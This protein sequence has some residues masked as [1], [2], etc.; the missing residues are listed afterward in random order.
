MLTSNHLAAIREVPFL[1]RFDDTTL[2]VFCSH[3]QHRAYKAG[4][5]LIKEGDA[6]ATLSSFLKAQL[7]CTKAM[8]HAATGCYKPHYNKAP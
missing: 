7:K 1:A 5:T 2:D 4:D 6:G 8:P 3:V